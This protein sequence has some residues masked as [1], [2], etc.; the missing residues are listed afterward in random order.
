MICM[1]SRNIICLETEWL[2]NENKY[3]FDLKSELFLQCLKEFHGIELIHR[4]ILNKN[5]LIHYMEYLAPAKRGMKKF[6]IIYI[7]CHGQTH[8][9]SLEGDEGLIDLKV[10]AELAQPYNFFKDRT[11]HFG[12]C[13]TLANQAAAEEFKATTGARL[14]CG[15]TK[16]VDAMKSAIA[17][18]ALFNHLINIKKDGSILNKERSKF[19]KSYSSI[20]GELGFVAY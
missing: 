18:M 3:K 15:Y 10:L 6:D 4:R 16:S 12:S 7:S 19:W 8:A 17:D 9:I 2:F 20:L 1:A 14:V 13:K 5:S 11:V